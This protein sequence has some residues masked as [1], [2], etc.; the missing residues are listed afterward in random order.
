MIC[1][2]FLYSFS[3]WQVVLAS[4]H[5]YV[6]RIHIIRANDVSQFPYSAQQPFCF[7]ETEF[8][9]VT[10]YQVSTASIQYHNSQSEHGENLTRER[11]KNGRTK[12]H[13]HKKKNK[14]KTSARAQ[15]YATT[16]TAH[17]NMYEGR[18]LCAWSAEHECVFVCEL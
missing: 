7:P 4:M 1:F 14:C 9:A 8:I 17:M 18:R 13:T 5:K 6:P 2:V 12:T 15:S 10:A 11:Y 3:F 16:T